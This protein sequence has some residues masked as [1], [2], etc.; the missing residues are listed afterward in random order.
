M[1]KSKLNFKTSPR[2]FIPTPP[3]FYLAVESSNIS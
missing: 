2:T 1:H 3:P